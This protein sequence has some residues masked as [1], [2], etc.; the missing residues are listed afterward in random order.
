MWPACGLG[1]RDALGAL[2]PPEMAVRLDWGGGLRIEGARCGRIRAASSAARP[3]AVPDWL[4]IGVEVPWRL[5]LAD[6]GL[7]PDR[8]AL[9]EEGCGELTPVR[10]LESWSR[11]MLGW[12]HRWEEE[13]AAPLH[14][15]WSGLLTG[16]GGPV[17]PAEGAPVAG[18]FLGLDERFGMILRTGQGTRAVPLASR[19]EAPPD[20]ASGGIAEAARDGPGARPAPEAERRR[21]P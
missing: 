2:G 16:L 14:A 15:E 1:L 21:A 11:H 20:A 18:A 4:V 7:A 17:T 6:P 3:E 10:L 13:G 19:L 5:D 9:M 12:I 8:T